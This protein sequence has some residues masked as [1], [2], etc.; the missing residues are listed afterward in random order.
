MTN[1]IDIDFSALEARVAAAMGPTL[2]EFRRATEA[3]RTLGMTFGEVHDASCMTASSMRN[4]GA[5]LDTVTAQ[6]P[7]SW[8][9]IPIDEEAAAFLATDPPLGTGR[10][11]E[12][13]RFMDVFDSFPEIA[14]RLGISTTEEGPR[15]SYSAPTPIADTYR[16]AEF[17]TLLNGT[18][19][20]LLA[21]H[22]QD[23]YTCDPGY[24]QVDARAIENLVDRPVQF[25]GNCIRR[26]F[27]PSRQRPE[28][29]MLR[30]SLIRHWV[31][32]TVGNPGHRA[33][34]G[35][36]LPRLV[37][38]AMLVLAGEIQPSV[39]DAIG[40]RLASLPVLD[41]DTQ[42]MMRGHY[43][44]LVESALYTVALVEGKSE[45]F[46]GSWAGRTI[47]RYAPHWDRE[48]QVL[49]ERLDGEGLHKK[50]VPPAPPAKRTLYTPKRLVMGRAVQVVSLPD[51]TVTLI[52][53]ADG[54]E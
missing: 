3:M 1:P 28:D 23:I 19:L 34:L 39:D 37:Q 6:F 30:C 5:T 44:F 25:V 36:L 53:K 26:S 27:G 50:A 47:N 52:P 35:D 33:T 31:D 12:Q 48:A 11:I 9:S 22:Y 38:D 43:Q 54:T 49:M 45:E 41:S 7:R 16:A 2:D 24:V 32:G 4:L 14:Q 20:S 8:Y 18:A 40:R 13:G 17:R 15:F 21:Q 46:A 42:W 29:H 51:G 10:N